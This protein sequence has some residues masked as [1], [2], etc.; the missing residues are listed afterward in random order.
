[1]PRAAR[2]APGLPPCQAASHSGLIT[3]VDLVS[4]STEQLTRLSAAPV[5]VRGTGFGDHVVFCDLA[6]TVHAVERI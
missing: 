5:L 3:A 2:A 6:G 1:M 4:G